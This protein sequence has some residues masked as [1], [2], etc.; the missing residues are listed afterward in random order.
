M[1]NLEYYN[2]SDFDIS[3]E[4][5]AELI[6]IIN[7]TFQNIIPKNLNK[8]KNYF[9]TLTIIND[10]IIQKLNKKYREI[11]KPT[12]VISLSY[13]NHID[14]HGVHNILGEIFISI[15]TAKKQ[16]KELKHDLLLELKF[17]FIHGVLH[18]LGYEHNEEKDFKTMM[19]LTNKI[20][21]IN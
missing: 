19:E 2:E 12:D 13:I 11:D 9:I 4:I 18:V 1:I 3:E 6:H 8:R 16:A 7:T 14:F 10:K 21:S 5:F 17:L 15:E 20:L